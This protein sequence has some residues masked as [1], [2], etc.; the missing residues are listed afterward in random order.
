MGFSPTPAPARREEPAGTGLLTLAGRGNYSYA[1][2]AF[3]TS[4]AGH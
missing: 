1:G 3:A 4:H 2:A